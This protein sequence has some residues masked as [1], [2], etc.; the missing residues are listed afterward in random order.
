MISDPKSYSPK[1]LKSMSLKEKRHKSDGM[2]KTATPT[3]TIT[4]APVPSL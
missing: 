2:Q 4:E 1:V 3:V